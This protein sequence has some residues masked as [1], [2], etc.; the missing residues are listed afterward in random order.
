MALE[1]TGSR[2]AAGA[3]WQR[4]VVLDPGRLNALA[5][6]AIHYWWWR[7]YDTAAMW[8][9]SAVATNALYGLGRVA[10]GQIALARGRH[11]EAESQ[12]GAAR[13][14]PTGP[15]SAGLSGFVSLAVAA[16][17]TVAA[18]R[19]VAEA[20][21]RTDPAAPNNH[22]AVN[23]AAAY[24]ALGEVSPALAWLDRYRPARD[25]PF[26]LHLRLEPPLHQLRNQARIQA[27]LLDKR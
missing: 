25:L 8:A 11:D 15:G 2:D 7:T 24:A 3:A 19:L 16:G 10:A 14:L 22:S 5:F 27:L 12:L 1:E 21:A 26:Q 4:A 17:D 6:L 13:R 23:I 20:E 18:R 9:D